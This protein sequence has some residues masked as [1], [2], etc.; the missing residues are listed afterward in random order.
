MR[1]RICIAGAFIAAGLLISSACTGDR[2]TASDPK[3][4]DDG[5]VRYV[6]LEGGFF[7][8]ETSAGR[9]LDPMNLPVEFRQDRLAVHVQGVVRTDAV[10]THMHGEIFEISEISRR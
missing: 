7:A 10:S 9:G 2:V 8:I 6:G 4:D 3:V 1:A 5:I